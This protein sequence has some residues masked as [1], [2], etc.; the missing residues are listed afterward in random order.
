MR[1]APS[2]A[3][4]FTRSAIFAAALAVLISLPIG[5]A[6]SHEAAVRQDLAQASRGYASHQ[7]AAVAHSDAEAVAHGDVTDSARRNTRSDADAAH[8][9]APDSE[10]RGAR[11][12]AQAA[13]DDAAARSAEA[14]LSG[15]LRLAI[16]NN[17]ELRA[18][19][20]RWQAGVHRISGARRLPEP[21]LGFGYFA[22]SVE[23]RVG[24]QRTRI[25]L[26]Q[27]FPWPTKL[28][29]GADAAAA[30]AR[31]LQRRF[32]AQALAVARRVATAYWELWQIRAT[33][34][35]HRE[36]SDVIRGL[37]E[38][39]RARMATGAA[40][41][42]DLQQ[43]D[44][45]VARIEDNIRSMDEAERGAEARLR[46][47]IGAAP[48]F[49][50]PTPDAPAAAA[51][52]A[53]LESA[54]S[55]EAL[56]ASARAHPMIE[57]RGLLAEASQASA[58]AKA[59]ERFP[60]I[61]LGVDW[62]ATG[63]A[64]A[65]GVPDSGRDALMV[66]AELRMPLW[67]GSTA[68]GIQAAEADARAERAEQRAL[69]HRA[70]AELAE[71]LAELRDSARRVEFYR[72][73]LVPQAESAYESVLGAYTVGRGTVAQTLLSQQ[74]LLELRIELERARADHARTWAELEEIVGRE[75]TPN[76]A[77]GA[78]AGPSPGES[79]E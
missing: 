41:L 33:R 6:G 39:A 70:E 40:M 75:L 37:S 66:G 21:T 8:V 5:C 67:R 60:D 65:M 31:A 43:I 17:P 74:D 53:E 35:I 12:T 4:A 20:E 73:T 50:T 71:T 54:L 62:I 9:N 47:V 36:H 23:T 1:F 11:S 58:R 32:E 18:S 76:A 64:D 22:R 34:A 14:G 79:D 48:G 63:D 28:S 56:S 38:S 10:R 59:A 68:D 30:R 46:A 26:Q 25:S 55:E 45:A 61:R 57:S 51:L 24:P 3:P 13:H 16:E 15:Y 29:A 77:G 42:A 78:G 7:E 52:P 69:V 49:A 19:F 44:L 2:F 72:V 27:A